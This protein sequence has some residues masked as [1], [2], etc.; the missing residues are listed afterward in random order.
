M[1]ALK[2]FGV[3]I[4]IVLV[5][6]AILP[7]FLP[8]EVAVSERILIET[9]P[10]TVFRQV[11]NY[12][13]WRSWS[14][15]ELGDP[16]MK[17]EYSGPE[18]G[19]GAIYSWTSEEMGDGNMT[20]LQSE[21]YKF[22]QS[23]LEMG[24]S[25]TAFD[26]WNFNESGA[27][28]EVI[29]TLRLKDLSYPFGRYFGAFLKSIMQPNQEKGLKRLKE[30]TEAFPESITIER[31]DLKAQPSIVI[32]DSTKIAGMQTT[33]KKAMDE[34]HVFM[35]RSNVN[36]SGPAFILYYNWDT[37]TYIKMRIG[38]PVFEEVKSQGRVEFYI[39][40]S[41]IAAKAV[42]YGPYEKLGEAHDEMAKYFDEF[43]LTYSEKPVWEEYLI[44][45]SNEPDSTKWQ[46]NIYYYIAE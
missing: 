12:K 34:L 8:E 18:S 32:F 42:S 36:A 24:S 25:G 29:W 3:L 30:V 26:E 40:P 27:G 33:M 7:V 22:I 45:P 11:N 43:D 6:L 16:Q 9:N 15:F 10:Q 23:R 31:V 19:K 20:I 46:T 38:F 1:R 35:K 37:T 44:D 14:P 17:S 4:L 2:F 28:T 13:N 21:P 39:R 5:I 41:G